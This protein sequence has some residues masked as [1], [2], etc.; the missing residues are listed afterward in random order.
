MLTRPK[1]CCISTAPVLKLTPG[2]TL[3]GESTML[4]G[5]LMLEQCAAAEL[6]RPKLSYALLSINPLTSYADALARLIPDHSMQ[7]AGAAG[8]VSTRSHQACP[9]CSTIKRTALFVTRYVTCQTFQ[10][11]CQCY[12]TWL[13]ISSQRSILRLSVCRYAEADILI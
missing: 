10:S 2:G 11:S 5:A 9:D 4:R 7:E 13:Y 6:H 12:L 8:S 3:E 1:G